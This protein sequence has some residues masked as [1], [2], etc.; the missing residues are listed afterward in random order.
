MIRWAILVA[1]RAR[2]QTFLDETVIR[3]HEWND[4]LGDPDNYVFSSQCQSVNATCSSS[5]SELLLT[6]GKRGEKWGPSNISDTLSDVEEDEAS[7]VSLKCPVVTA[8][9]NSLSAFNAGS[10]QA[11]TDIPP[12]TVY[13]YWDCRIFFPRELSI[14]IQT[15]AF[16]FPRGLSVL[17]ET[18]AFSFPRGLSVRIET[19]PFSFPRGL[20]VL[21]EIVAFYF[22]RG[23]SIL[24]ETVAFSFPRG[25][26]VLTQTVA[27][28]FIPSKGIQKCRL[29]VEHFCPFHFPPSSSQSRTF[30]DFV[31]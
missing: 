28:S 26:S 19:V 23:L 5:F 18:V 2:C 17:I 4:R 1:R 22:P 25:L 27:F 14:L 6:E 15:V 13:P 10:N 20:S 9:C 3:K 12:K 31:S 7:Q 11:Q 8:G 16:S 30:S 29:K 24:I 21:I